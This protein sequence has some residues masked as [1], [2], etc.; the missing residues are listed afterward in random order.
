[1]EHLHVELIELALSATQKICDAQCTYIL[2]A[3]NCT[4]PQHHIADVLAAN[5][6]FLFCSSHSII[7]I[8][9][10]VAPTGVINHKNIN[11]WQY[12]QNLTLVPLMSRCKAS[13]ASCES[14]SILLPSCQEKQTLLS[15]Q[16]I[17]IEPEYTY[18]CNT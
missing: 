15:L 12:V 17:D 2:R 11:L 1:M 16:I 5:N 9:T 3:Q 13:L 10:Y 6:N 7:V 14:W 4:I 18:V 8:K